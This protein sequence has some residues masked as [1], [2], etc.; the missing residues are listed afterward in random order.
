MYSYAQPDAVMFDNDKYVILTQL[1]C[2]IGSQPIR[3]N[4]TSWAF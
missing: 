3:K 4:T 1:S 2:V